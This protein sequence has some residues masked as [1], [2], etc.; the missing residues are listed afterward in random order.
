[1]DSL[2][3]KIFFKEQT[4]N[5]KN[6]KNDEKSMNVIKNVCLF[7]LRVRIAGSSL[8]LGVVYNLL[9]CGCCRYLFLCRRAWV[10]ILQGGEFFFFLKGARQGVCELE[11]KPRFR[12]ND[13]L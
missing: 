2:L 11:K 10:R 8:T 9:S 6:T 12:K 5:V 13:F 1:M 4:R 3:I 7:C